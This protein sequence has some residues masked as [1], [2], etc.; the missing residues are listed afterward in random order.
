[1][2]SVVLHF[3]PTFGGVSYNIELLCGDHVNAVSVALHHRMTYHH[4]KERYMHKQDLHKWICKH[5]ML[6][7]C[8]M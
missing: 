3:D 8:N 5:D 2:V 7:T 1:M 6:A 4:G